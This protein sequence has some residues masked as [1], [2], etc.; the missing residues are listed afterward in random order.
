MRSMI[1]VLRQSWNVF[2]YLKV[3]DS[4]ADNQH[5]LTIFMNVHLYC[6]VDWHT[7][8]KE[9]GQQQMTWR[10]MSMLSSCPDVIHAMITASR[11][12]SRCVCL[13]GILSPC[14]VRFEHIPSVFLSPVS[15][16]TWLCGWKLSIM[17]T[18]WVL[19]YS[20]VYMNGV[21]LHC[22]NE[23]CRDYLFCLY[24]YLFAM[25]RCSHA[26]WQPYKCGIFSLC[27]VPIAQIYQEKMIFNLILWK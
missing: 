5:H 13:C 15:F 23:F 7:G 26:L 24:F 6:E 25:G 14:W 1:T 18:L 22:G 2:K 20:I 19:T 17:S 10:E 4:H 11:S 12:T 9:Q 27:F 3:K 21:L 8:S 16:S